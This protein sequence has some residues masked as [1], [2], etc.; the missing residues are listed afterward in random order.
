MQV[1]TEAVVVAQAPLAGVDRAGVLVVEASWCGDALQP[2]VRFAFKCSATYVLNIG[3]DV[4]V[5]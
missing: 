1:V 4:Q 2:H 5:R 3:S